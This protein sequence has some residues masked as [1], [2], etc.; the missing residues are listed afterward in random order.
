M[1]EELLLQIKKY[2]SKKQGYNII[3]TKKDGQKVILFNLDLRE[4]KLNFFLTFDKYKDHIMFQLFT[5]F[6]QPYK[7]VGV[8]FYQVVSKL[9]LMSI[10]GSLIIRSHED[11][12]YIS[13]KSNLISTSN[14][15]I[16]GD[17]FDLFLN[18]SISMLVLFNKEL[19]S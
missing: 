13:Y 19:H 6:E 14:A 10:M 16:N 15:I 7:T 3:E 11:M 4:I 18:G 9:N 2:I 17:A 8:D 12:Y 1:E 5:T